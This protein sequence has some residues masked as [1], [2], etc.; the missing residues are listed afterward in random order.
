MWHG[1]TVPVLSTYLTLSVLDRMR[2]HRCTNP[3]SHKMA[4]SEMSIFGSCLS[5]FNSS[6]WKPCL[7]IEAV[8]N[9]IWSPVWLW[10]KN[11]IIAQLG[12]INW[13]HFS[14]ENGQERQWHLAR[15]L[16]F[17]CMLKYTYI[18]FHWLKRLLDKCPAWIL[19]PGTTVLPNKA[20]H[21]YLLCH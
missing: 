9:K 10:S 3:R 18:W 1:I 19:A 20:S 17:V 21:I 13:N 4:W 16:I 14:Q 8:F 12:F 2:S 15:W 11:Q 6:F 7:D 5:C